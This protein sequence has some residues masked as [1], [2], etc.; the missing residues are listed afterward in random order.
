M[1]INDDVKLTDPKYILVEKRSAFLHRDIHKKNRNRSEFI[2]F[3]TTEN[4]LSEETAKNLR[5]CY[6]YR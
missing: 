1:K 2:E 4:V 6:V 3:F 5:R